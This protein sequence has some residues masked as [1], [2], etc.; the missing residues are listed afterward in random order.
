MNKLDISKPC[1]WL[2]NICVMKNRTIEAG[3]KQQQID[4]W[5][6]LYSQTIPNPKFPTNE[7]MTIPG[8]VIQNI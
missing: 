5:S 2:K 1:E 7:L 4:K 8:A 6:Q 3:Q